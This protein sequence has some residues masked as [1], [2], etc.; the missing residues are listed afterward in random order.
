M[1]YQPTTNFR[2]SNGVDLGRK[3]VT[4][5]YLLSVYGSILDSATST[6]L[7]V[8][9]ALWT[10]G[11]NN[12]LGNNTTVNASTPVTTFSGGTNWKQVSCGGYVTAAI[13]TNGTLWSWGNN[14]SGSLGINDTINRST[15]VT[16]ILGGTDWKLINITPAG[17]LSAIKNDG[18]LWV[19]GSNFNGTLGINNTIARSTPVTTIL[20]GNNWKQSSGS[21][22]AVKTDGTLWIW[23]TNT[24]GQLGINDAVS[25]STPVTTI[26][27]GN[28]WKQVVQG[29]NHCAA[30]KTDGTLWTWGN[31]GVGVLGINDVFSRSTPVTTI[32]GGNNWKSVSC[33]ANHMSAIKTDGT[34][35]IWG[36]NADG[37]L[38]IDGSTTAHRSIP[39][40]TILGGTNWKSVSCGIA[41]VIALKTN[42]TLWTWGRGNLGQLGINST[43]NRSTPVTVSIGGTN[44][45]SVSGGNNHTAAIQSVDII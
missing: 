29:S 9:P 27:G 34:L 33:G 42:G 37:Q 19:W 43:T 25:R 3:L 12:S 2:D 6:G 20:G 32:L 15:P 22:A 7:T 23:G 28:N 11:V 45:K 16:T 24:L 10:W 38:G 26:L 40:T 1:P 31:A 8:T 4:K 14:P 21:N 13:K 41:H 30:V 5:D 39:V 17:S 36:S 44:W 35:W 18:T